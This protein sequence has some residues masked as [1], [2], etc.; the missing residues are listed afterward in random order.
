M[1][2]ETGFYYYG[3]RYLDPKTSRWLSAD[4]ALGEYIPAAPVNDETRRRN[5][6]LPGMG[7]IFNMVNLH[8]YHYAGNNP[9]KYVDPNGREIVSF[10]AFYNMSKIEGKLGNSTKENISDAGCYI[11][12]FANIKKFMAFVNITYG[13]TYSSANNAVHA[14]NN[15]KSLFGKNSGDLVDR[16]TSMD[17]IFGKGKWDYFTRGG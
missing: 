16:E 3:A 10:V 15:D 4:P 1:D 7:G 14:I 9:V 6:N 17:V 5:G 13:Y 8:V 11:T 12:T 2:E